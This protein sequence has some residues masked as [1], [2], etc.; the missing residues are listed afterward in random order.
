MIPED[1]T[2][3]TQYDKRIHVVTTRPRNEQG[4]KKILGRQ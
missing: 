2:N 4:G 1:T 3:M